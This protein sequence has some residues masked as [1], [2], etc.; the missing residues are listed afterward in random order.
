MKGAVNRFQKSPNGTT[1]MLLEIDAIP[2]AASLYNLIKSAGLIQTANK[3]NA[4]K[5]RYNEETLLRKIEDL[6]WSNIIKESSST[7][8]TLQEDL[9]ISDD[10]E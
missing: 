3:K 2:K 9:E 7:M 1:H 6:S 10:D 5:S 4:F 8:T